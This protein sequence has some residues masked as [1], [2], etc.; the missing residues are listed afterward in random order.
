MLLP[1]RLGQPLA[2]RS[3]PE[4]FHRL[5]LLLEAVV[6]SLQ[7]AISRAC[8]IKLALQVTELNL[9]RVESLENA[10]K[11]LLAGEQVIRDLSGSLHHAHIY[12][13]D[14]ALG[15]DFSSFFR[16]FLDPDQPAR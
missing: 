15:Q 6:G 9:H 2:S 7:F 4:A 13:S 8:L 3:Q 12:V 14:G 1:R 16:N 5:V 10:T 11:E